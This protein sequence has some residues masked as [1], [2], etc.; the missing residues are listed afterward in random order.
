MNLN[1]LCKSTVCLNNKMVN[2]IKSKPSYWIIL[3]QWWQ[4]LAGSWCKTWNSKVNHLLRWSLW[5]QW[6]W[7]FHN[8]MRRT[9]KVDTSS[10][11]LV[12]ATHSCCMLLK[13]DWRTLT[14]RR[15]TSLKGCLKLSLSRLL[16][17][18]RLIL[19]Q[20]RQLFRR[21]CNCSVILTIIISQSTPCKKDLKLVLLE[22]SKKEVMSLTAIASIPKPRKSINCLPT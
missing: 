8:L 7:L 19:S 1:L 4:L 18:R 10:K 16:S 17:I 5:W 21:W 20:Q 11:M 12:S 14:L 13:M 9:N 6:E 15:M 22:T 2:L 3:R